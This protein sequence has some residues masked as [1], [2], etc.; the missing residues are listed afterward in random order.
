M[1]VSIATTHSH[2][3]LDHSLIPVLQ[4]QLLQ[5]HQIPLPL[6]TIHL[7]LIPLPIYLRQLV[8]KHKLLLQFAFQQSILLVLQFLQL[9]LQQHHLS[10]PIE[11]WSWGPAAQTRERSCFAL[12]VSGISTVF[13]RFWIFPEPFGSFDGI[14][15]LDM[16]FL[17][18]HF[19]LG[20]DVKII[21]ILFVLVEMQHVFF[22]VAGWCWLF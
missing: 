10:F 18:S 14:I 13:G 3:I 2:T 11:A 8:L 17:G 1:I 5:L 6:L 9:I 15:L 22:V 19:P 4:Q 12:H 21:Q 7:Q 16:L 20:R